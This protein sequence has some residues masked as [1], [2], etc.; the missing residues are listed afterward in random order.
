MTA[1]DRFKQRFTAR[2]WGGVILA[3]AVHFAVL[4]LWPELTAQDIGIHR[5][6]LQVHDIIP[7]FELPPPP[8]NIVRPAAPVVPV[9]P[10]P[11]DATM[12][13]STWEHYT[14]EKLPP[15]PDPEERAGVAEGPVFVPHTVKPQVRNLAEVTRALE[16][17]YPPLLRDAGI[18]GV[19]YVWFF[20]D[21]DGAVQRTRVDKTSGHPTLDAAALKVADVIRFSPALNLD[22]RVAVWISFPIRFQVR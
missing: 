20:V 8:E 10:V 13:P 5:D 12:A 6:A 19:V 16:R 15:P 14:P 2:L 3:T 1:N 17:E 22:K 7:E 21:E 11:T 4:A 18:G 9:A